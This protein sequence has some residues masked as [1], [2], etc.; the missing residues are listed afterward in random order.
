M[1]MLAL[2]GWCRRRTRKLDKGAVESWTA[3]D[4]QAW[5]RSFRMGKHGL[6]FQG[7]VGRELLLLSE[8]EVLEQVSPKK[9]AVKIA[10]CLQKLQ[11]VISEAT[12]T[13]IS[14]TSRDNVKEKI[15]KLSMQHILVALP[16]AGATVAL[17]AT[18]KAQRLEEHTLEG[19]IK[20]K[21]WSP[22]DQASRTGKQGVHWDDYQR[23]G[24][25]E[26]PI[27]SRG[28]PV[29]VRAMT[30]IYENRLD[31]A[32][33]SSS[34]TSVKHLVRQFEP[35]NDEKENKPESPVGAKAKRSGKVKYRSLDSPQKSAL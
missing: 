10:D 23:K 21:A 4:V 27:G 8:V 29:S 11:E 20:I 31:N 35:A 30:S 6:R 1:T 18:P 34:P 25:L 7:L 28:K 26:E 24:G 15:R 16:A 14:A 13:A 9:D 12:A 19:V 32:K 5:L 2:F 17:R 22:A 33:L 3:Q